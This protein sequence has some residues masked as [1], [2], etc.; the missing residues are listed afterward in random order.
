MTNQ[1]ARVLHGVAALGML[2][3]FACRNPPPST[4]PAKPTLSSLEIPSDTFGKGFSGIVPAVRAAAA[5]ATT[6]EVFDTFFVLPLLPATPMVRA[7]LSS[8]YP[9]DLT[10][11]AASGSGAAVTLPQVPNGNQG[12]TTGFFQV[13]TLVPNNPAT[14]TI[15]IRYP[16]TFQGSKMI[17]T[18][19]TDTV[20]GLASAPLTFNMSFR[21]STLMVSIVTD[22][23]DGKVTSTP[24]GIDCPPTCSADF[25]TSTNVVLQQSVLHNQTEF[26][27][28]TGN[29]VGGG[30]TCS[31]SLLVPGGPIVPFNPTVAANFRTH[32]NSA[33]PSAM[34]CPAAPLISGKTWVAQPNCGNVLFTTLMCDGQGYFCCGAQT[35]TPSPRCSGQ[36]LTAATCS[37]SPIA[38]GPVNQQLI[39]PGGCYTTP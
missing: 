32:V 34:S 38:G 19:I 10:V 8:P 20:G 24:A 1:R 14:W 39:Q 6:P 35:G 29:C 3:L 33:I 36:N 28:W 2:A 7:V 17:S 11:T 12:P 31:V 25:T 22:N 37:T 23:A 16:D 9:S 30:N 26:I 13:I 21:G 27:G 4:P 18:N 15:F 5:T